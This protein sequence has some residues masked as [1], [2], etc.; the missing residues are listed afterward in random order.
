VARE[1]DDAAVHLNDLGL[2]SVAVIRL[3]NA[4]NFSGVDS[5]ADCMGSGICTTGVAAST[6][7]RGTTV[8]LTPA[9]D[10]KAG[11]ALHIPIRLRRFMQRSLRDQQRAIVPRRSARKRIEPMVGSELRR[12]QIDADID[13]R[14]SR[15]SNPARHGPQR[16]AGRD[17][18]RVGEPDEIGN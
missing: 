15:S 11:N 8:V 12:L 6:C 3:T 7:A 1:R 17:R 4:T 13:R 9:R 2:A 10:D 5:N 16:L 18:R 14:E